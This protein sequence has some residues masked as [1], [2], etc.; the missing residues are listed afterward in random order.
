MKNIQTH[1]LGFPR[2]G[3]QREL[4]AALESH[5]R[6]A[7]SEA[8]LE[9]TG[10][11]LRARHW[12]LQAEAGL[13]HVTVGDFAYYDQVANH[14]QLFGCEPARFGFYEQTPL[15]RYFIMA[16]GESVPHRLRPSMTITA[17][18]ATTAATRS[19]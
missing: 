13:D 9:A 6:G 17:A 3:A 19:T 1:V 14:I 12:A 15:A 10:A 18:G 7:T 11:Q 4:K 16:R 2:I 5:W 8:E